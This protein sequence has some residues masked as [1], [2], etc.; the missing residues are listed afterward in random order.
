M[1]WRRKFLTASQRTIVFFVVVLSMLAALSLWEL[2]FLDSGRVFLVG[3]NLWASAQRRATFCLLSYSISESSDDLQCFRSEMAVLV[4]DMQARRELDTKRQTYSIIAAGLIQGRNRPA[5]V[6]TAIVFYNI[7]PWNSEVE[8][9]IQIWRDSD[10][11]TLRLIAIADE[12]QHARNDTEKKRVREELLQI[13]DPLSRMERDFA[14]HLNNGMHFLALCLCFVQAVFALALVFLAIIVTRRMMAVQARADKQVR[15]LAFYDSL[16]GL[17]NRTLL[18]ERLATALS[19]ARDRDREVAVLF[20]DLDEFKVINDSLGHSVGDLLLK[21]VARRL[22]EL[23]RDQD[24]VARLG[25]DEF[26]VVLASLEHESDAKQIAE[27]ILKAVGA[28]FVHD[29]VL[30]NVTCSIGVGLFPK[31]GDDTETLIKFADA[32]MYTAK[33]A[34][35]NRIRFFEEEMNEVVVRRLSLENRLRLALQRQ[36][37]YLVYQP[38][39]NISTGCITGIEALLRWNYADSTSMPTDKFIRACE[40]SGLIIPIGEWVMKTACQQAR[41]WQEQ[42]LPALPMAINVSAIQFRED[43]F[44]D[45]IRHVLHQTG[46]APE[47][48]E[49]ELT[50]GLLLSNED[51]VFGVLKE[52]RSMGVDLTIDDFGTGYSSLSYLRQFPVTSLKIDKSFVKNV[53]VNHDDAS[54][55]TAIISLAR[56]LRTYP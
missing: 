23:I 5:D 25:G 4:G 19:A 14:E 6:P 18:R 34:G 39:M 26:L 2:K 43:G 53:T 30:L 33:E 54:I 42:G 16:T 27:R 55:V 32:A 56:S 45:L 36:E 3:E 41:K 37:F 50:E 24:T 31:H 13:E 49:L 40:N 52:I 29:G 20:L 46:L 35:R 44:C 11:Y 17:P 12:L 38:Q 15:A 10:Q 7:A 22:Q 28:S 51:V 1:K 21:E 9:A 48:L 8:K 47:Y